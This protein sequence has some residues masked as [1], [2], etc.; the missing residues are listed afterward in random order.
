MLLKDDTINIQNQL[1]SFCRTGQIMSIEGTLPG[2]LP[3]YRRLVYNV[4]YG[5]LE[6]SFPI[7]KSILTEPEFKDLV[8]AYLEKHDAKEP[9]V[10]KVPG[11]FYL[12]INQSENSIIEKYSYLPDL[13]ALEWSE[14]LVFNRE[15]RPIPPF[16]AFEYANEN[17]LVINPDFEILEL[18]YPVHKGN[19]EEISGKKSKFV[20]L[21]FRNLENKKVHYLE[22]SSLYKMLI[23]FLILGRAIG[24]C[25]N[26]IHAEFGFDSNSNLEKGIED[27][28]IKCFQ[29]GFILGVYKFP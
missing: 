29:Q 8:H 14:I 18:N 1:A 22:I 21:A 15:D 5:L 20:L 27:F 11:E 2:R 9:Q 23:E 24:E 26:Q 17:V 4:M 7:C 3:H 13:L 6:K 10:W 25:I 19:W 12:F 16:S 28:L